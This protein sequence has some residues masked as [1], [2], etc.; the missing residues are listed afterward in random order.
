M[1]NNLEFIDF[2]EPPDMSKATFMALISVIDYLA[3]DEYRRWRENGSPAKGHVYC[4]L[5]KLN[6]WALDVIERMELVDD[7]PVLRR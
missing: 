1:E 4:D 6:D 7:W 2:A 3:D 5:L